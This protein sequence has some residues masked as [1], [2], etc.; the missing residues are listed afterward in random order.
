VTYAAARAAR[1]CGAVDGGAAL[2]AGGVGVDE[3]GGGL[4]FEYVVCV[5]VEWSG[6]GGVG[7]ARLVMLAG[8]LMEG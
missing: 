6:V 3:D 4:H 5:W 7:V 8:K 2:G 1:L